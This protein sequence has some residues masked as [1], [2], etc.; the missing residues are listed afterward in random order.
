MDLEVIVYYVS[1]GKFIGQLRFCSLMCTL[2]AKQT[3]DGL[4]LSMNRDD[5]VLRQHKTHI[6]S[7][8]FVYPLVEDIDGTWIGVRSDGQVY[9]LLNGEE[10]NYSPI[11]SRGDI[12]PRLLEGDR[13]LSSQHYRPFQLFMYSPQKGMEVFSWNGHTLQRTNQF[14]HNELVLTSSKYGYDQ[15]KQE[16]VRENFPKTSQ[17][18]KEIL[19]DVGSHIY[20][21]DHPTETIASSFIEINKDAILFQSAYEPSFKHYKEFMW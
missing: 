21:K 9:A 8:H 5:S 10:M 18:F 19:R 17:E 15:G 7:L 12:V 14:E 3:L 4:L 16:H 13:T 20:L 11:K 2:I 1:Y 6:E